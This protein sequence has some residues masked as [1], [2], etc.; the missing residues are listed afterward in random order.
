MFVLPSFAQTRIEKELKSIPI[1]SRPGKVVLTFELGFATGGVL[2]SLKV[3][4]FIEDEERS[5]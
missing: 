5:C 3:K 4:R 2:S 1:F